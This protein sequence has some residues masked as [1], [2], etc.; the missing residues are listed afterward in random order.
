MVLASVYG[1]YHAGRSMW[2]QWSIG[3]AVKAMGTAIGSLFFSAP[4]PD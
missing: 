4:S 1:P 3:M 2:R